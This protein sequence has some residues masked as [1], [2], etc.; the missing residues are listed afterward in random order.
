MQLNKQAKINAILL[1]ATALVAAALIVHAE[2]ANTGP[3]R[4]DAEVACHNCA[5]G[6]W[7]TGACTW[8]QVESED[9]YCGRCVTGFNCGKV[10][11]HAAESVSTFTNGE[12]GPAGCIGGDLQTEPSVVTDQNRGISC[13]G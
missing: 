9:A 4:N 12:C 1:S 5:T 11:T 10:G 2:C 7:S 3:S 13:G 8:H 6:A